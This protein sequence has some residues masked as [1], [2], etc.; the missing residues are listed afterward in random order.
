MVG[1]AINYK[2]FQFCTKLVRPCTLNKEKGSF[3][4]EVS[5]KQ[6]HLP[7]AGRKV[8]M[9]LVRNELLQYFIDVLHLLR[10]RLSVCIFLPKVKK[11]Y[12]AYCDTMEQ[13]GV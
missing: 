11:L 1:V 7:R 13:K 5:S 6:N 4:G 12:Y 8:E 9:E 10:A 3:A 2:D